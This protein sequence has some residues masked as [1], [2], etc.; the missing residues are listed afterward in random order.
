[1]Y[2]GF[3]GVQVCSLAAYWR[4]H[5]DHLS[6]LLVTGMVPLLQGRLRHWLGHMHHVMTA[7]DG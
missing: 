2:S 3:S 4:W 6:H 7:Y 1:M 5:H